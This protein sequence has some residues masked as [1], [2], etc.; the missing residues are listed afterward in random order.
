MGVRRRE[1][2]KKSFDY[3]T[4]VALLGSGFV[5]IRKGSPVSDVIATPPKLV[6]G[7]FFVK[8]LSRI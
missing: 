2:A 1:I 4:S 6:L 3:E 5:G 8:D 7:S